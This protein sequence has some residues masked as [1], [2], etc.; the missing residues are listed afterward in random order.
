MKVFVISLLSRK[1]RL[2][3]T[4]IFYYVFLNSTKFTEQNVF[5]SIELNVIIH[6]DTMVF[7][8]CIYKNLWNDLN[9][10]EER[11]I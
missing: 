7:Q 8:V 3:F 2:F 9:Y 6:D 11:H 1:T 10:K 5:E 4:S